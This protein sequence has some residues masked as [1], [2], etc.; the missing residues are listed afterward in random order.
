MEREASTFGLTI[1]TNKVKVLILTGVI[2]FL[3]ALNGGALKTL[4]NLFSFVALFLL[5][6][7]SNSMLSDA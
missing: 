1:N 7:A 4:T 6:V 2:L 3:S 5:K